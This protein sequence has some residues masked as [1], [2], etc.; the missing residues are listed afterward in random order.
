MRRHTKKNEKQTNN[1]CVNTQTV[2]RIVSTDEK[3]T[4]TE[5]NKQTNKHQNRDIKRTNIVVVQNRMEPEN[6]QVGCTFM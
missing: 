6:R 5:A 4:N 3:Q 1:G 2:I